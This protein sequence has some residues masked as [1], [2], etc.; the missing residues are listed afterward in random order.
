MEM[1]LLV[2]QDFEKLA[3]IS[4]E[5]PTILPIFGWVVLIRMPLG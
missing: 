4:R 2:F 1:E 3:A 5:Q